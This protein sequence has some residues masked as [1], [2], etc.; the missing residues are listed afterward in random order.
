MPFINSFFHN[1]FDSSEELVR[2]YRTV[3]GGVLI[4]SAVSESVILERKQNNYLE[5]FLWQYMQ[6]FIESSSMAFSLQKQLS[7]LF[8]SM[9]YLSTINDAF[10]PA[11]LSQRRELFLNRTIKF[12]RLLLADGQTIMP[13]CSNSQSCELTL[14]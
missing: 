8:L 13:F 1:L 7:M 9:K 12:A 4:S 3:L 10:P 2:L 5:L 6:S 11:M 14:Q